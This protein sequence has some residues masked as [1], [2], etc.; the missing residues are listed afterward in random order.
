M[1]SYTVNGFQVTCAE[2]EGEPRIWR[3]ECPEFQRRGIEFKEGFCA[4]TA[5]AIEHLMLENHGRA[6]PAA[7]T[8]H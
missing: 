4:H 5:I 1:I 7:R 2:S 3:C 6:S 8:A